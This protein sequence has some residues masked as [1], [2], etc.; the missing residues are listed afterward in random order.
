MDEDNVLTTM[1][2]EELASMGQSPDG[3]T[4]EEE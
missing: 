2:E 1:G 3:D 4:W